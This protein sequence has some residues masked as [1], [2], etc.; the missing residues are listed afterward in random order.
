MDQQIEQKIVERGQEFF[1][2]ISGEAPSIFNKGW[3]TGKVMDWSMKNEEFKVQVFRF[4]DVL[5]Y[6]NTSESLLRHIREYFASSGSE[7]PSVL[8]WGAG[9]AGLGGALTAKIMGGAIRSN[10]ESMG[11][12]FIIG[13]NVK[14]AMGGLAK[15]SGFRPSGTALPIWRVN[16]AAIKSDKPPGLPDIGLPFGNYFAVMKAKLN[17]TAE[18]DAQ[19]SVASRATHRTADLRPGWRPPLRRAGGWCTCRRNH[20]LMTCKK[21]RSVARAGPIVSIF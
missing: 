9:K 1:N 8:R 5:P 6:L 17:L 20:G 18:Q 14:E 12:Q 21:P 16:W 13:Q 7:V 4:V 3:W 2:S 15:L 11:R 19:Y 10:I